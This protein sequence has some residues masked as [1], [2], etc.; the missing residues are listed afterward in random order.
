MLHDNNKSSLTNGHKLPKTRL[1]ICKTNCNNYTS[2]K[3]PGRVVAR[4]LYLSRTI[5]GNTKTCSVFE[6]VSLKR[7]QQI[8][9]GLPFL[10]AQTNWPT[11]LDCF[12]SKWVRNK[13]NWVSEGVKK[14]Q[15]LFF[16][17]KKWNLK[18]PINSN[19][20]DFGRGVS[21]RQPRGVKELLKH[22]SN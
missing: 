9:L 2:Y 13:P 4:L 10:G 3:H 15:N 12:G 14:K 5:T 11:P 17:R 8:L 16:W 7:D 1:N 22:P 20:W 19:L 21:H 18:P 6:Q